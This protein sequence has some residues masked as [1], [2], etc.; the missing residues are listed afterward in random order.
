MVSNLNRQFYHRTGGF[1]FIYTVSI[2]SNKSYKLYDAVQQNEYLRGG[3]LPKSDNNTPENEKNNDIIIIKKYPNRRLYN[4]STS[5]YIVL[6]DLVELVKSGNPFEIR[7]TKTGND[8]TRE[9]LNQ[10][11]FERETGKSNFH[12]PLEVQ[13]QLI[14]MYDDTYGKMMPSYLKES[15][16]VFSAERERMKSTME[17]V[18][19]RNTKAMMEFSQN[20][21][22]QNLEVFKRSWEMF[23]TNHANPKS[24]TDKT[25]NEAESVK[26]NSE[27]DEIQKQ[28]NQLQ[29][30][31]KNLK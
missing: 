27:L 23:G 14:G 6:D 11:I 12:F 16:D 4:T 19:E 17:N 26:D 28:I 15:L 13:K 5:A 24:K 8:I 31:L 22:R 20:I 21:A 7:D 10:I 9:I 3:I 30:R 25:E 1:L 2:A 18:V 29:D